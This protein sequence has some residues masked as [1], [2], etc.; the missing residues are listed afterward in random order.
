M[1][2]N[3]ANIAL[4]VSSLGNG[5][6]LNIMQIR[7]TCPYYPLL[8]NCA[9]AAKYTCVIYQCIIRVHDIKLHK[10]P[11][12]CEYAWEQLQSKILIL[13]CKYQHS[14]NPG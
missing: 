2:S 11:S 5:S 6:G 7:I 13:I 9:Q 3:K 1:V 14:S 12:N 8:K 4:T 10:I